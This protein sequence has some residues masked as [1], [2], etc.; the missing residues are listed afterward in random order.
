M[1]FGLFH[2]LQA[3]ARAENRAIPAKGLTGPGYD[4]HAF[5]DTESY[6]L[7]V[8]TLTLPAAAASALRW[9]HSTL[10][11]AIDRAA[12]LGLA[13]RCLPVADD[14]RP[15]VLRL[16]ACR[17][18]RLPCQRGH[19]ERGDPLRRRHRRRGVR[20]RH[21]DGPADAHRTAVALARPPRRRGRLPHRR[22]DRPGRVQRAVRRQRL[23]QPAGPAEPGG[24]GGRGAAVPGPGAPAR[25]RHGG[26]GRLAG[27][28]G[29]DVHPV[30][31][32]A[33]R[34]PAG[35]PGTPGTRPGT[36]PG[37]GRTSIR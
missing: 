4:G 9:R 20:P 2:V 25:H 32:D 17:H 16:L 6:V 28:R 11:L 37:P 35:R 29:G 36:S 13:G 30:R 10:P 1:R 12:Q 26:V 18:R 24:R 8:L 34:A 33:R 19:R 21:G 15:R 31:R 23:H 3:G 14:H 7:P 22:G 27:R 5:W